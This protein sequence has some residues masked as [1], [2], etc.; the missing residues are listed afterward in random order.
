M[1][2]WNDDQEEEQRKPSSEEMYDFKQIEVLEGLKDEIRW[3]KRRCWLVALVIAVVGS[4]IGVVGYF[5]V[6]PL[7]GDTV[8]NLVE[9]QLKRTTEAT[10]SAEVAA[11]VARN[12]AQ[13]ASDKMNDAIEKANSYGEEVKAL[14]TRAAELNQTFVVL[15]QQLEANTANLK[16][17]GRKDVEQIESRLA[18]LEKLVPD[19]SEVSVK[20]DAFT[21]YKAELNAKITKTEKGK[22]E[23]QNNSEYMVV[24]NYR[25]W[26]KSFSENIVQKLSEKGFRATAS[27]ITI[28]DEAEI[29]VSAPMSSTPEV[30]T[31]SYYWPEDAEKAGFVRSI[32]TEVLPGDFKIEMKQD[33]KVSD[34]LAKQK[35]DKQLGVDFSKRIDVFI[36]KRG[37]GYF[38]F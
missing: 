1:T 33:M 37:F 27:L 18:G 14:Q 38:R 30:V 4:F 26:A 22:T 9:N 2:A 7:I 12:L 16:E 28:T 10:S 20:K 3:A 24:V 5:W 23:F 29:I 6:P 32:V 35:L 13:R 36:D 34:L 25:V 15:R 21:A 31:I 11:L 8:K 17:L 19:L